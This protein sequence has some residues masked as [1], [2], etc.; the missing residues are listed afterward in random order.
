[1]WESALAPEV[2]ESFGGD[3]PRRG[4]V[5][6]LPDLQRR[7]LPRRHQRVHDAALRQ[8]AARDV[9]FKGQMTQT[10]HGRKL[11]LIFIWV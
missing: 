7:G 2:D 1:M 10:F 8:F 6:D 9:G 11:Q 4:F 3:D 5:R